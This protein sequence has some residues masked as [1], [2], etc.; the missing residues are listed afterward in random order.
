MRKLIY[1]AGLPILALASPAFGQVTG[2][3]DIDGSVADRCL[4]TTDNAVISVGELT[5]SGSGTTAGKLDASKLD[6]E[7]RTLVGWC[8]GTA[9]TMEV[10]AL[11]LLNTDFV[12]VVPAGFDTRVDYTATADA[13]SLS[14]DDTSLSAGKGSAVAVGLFSGNIDVTLSASSS[15]TNGLLVA[16]G[17]VGQ[18]IVTLTPNISFGSPE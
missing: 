16:G 11:P 12:G 15:P 10:E 6:G 17:Y 9:A 14:G 18:V 7:T 2:T 13:N 1:L 8:N 4:F 3:V 5:L